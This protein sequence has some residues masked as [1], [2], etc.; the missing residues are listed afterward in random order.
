MMIEVLYWKTTLFVLIAAVA[1]VYGAA[2]TPTIAEISKT[3]KNVRCLRHRPRR[4]GKANK[5]NERCIYCRYFE[6]EHE[7]AFGAVG[8]DCC[9]CRI[10]NESEVDCPDF[11]E[12]K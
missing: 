6:S 4:P 5:M 10:C 3:T 9:S 2:L 8:E 12:K 11:E 1:T 7:G